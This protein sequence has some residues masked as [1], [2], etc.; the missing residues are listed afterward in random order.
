MLR[1]ITLAA[2]FGVQFVFSEEVAGG[3]PAAQGIASTDAETDVVP[4]HEPEAEEVQVYESLHHFSSY[5]SSHFLRPR[6]PRSAQSG[7]V[8]PSN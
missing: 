6:N 7:N 1:L 3:A 2:V 8:V 5:N 4:E